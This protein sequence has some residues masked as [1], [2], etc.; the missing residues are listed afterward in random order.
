MQIDNTNMEGILHKYDY[1]HVAF[2]FTPAK[3]PNVLIMIGGMTDGLLTVPYVTQ[4]PEILKPFKYSVIQIQLTS[5]FKGWGTTN[6][7]QDVE[8]IKSLIEYLKSDTQGRDKI[9]IM[10]HSTGSQDVMTYLLTYSDTV[11]A[12]IMQ[13]SVSDREAFIMNGSP[14]HIN[15]L[16]LKAQEL[17]RMGKSN[18]LLSHEY[19]KHTFGTPITAYRWCSLLVPEGDD[20]FFSS[21][22]SVEALK[23][24]FGQIKK[25]FLVA[26]SAEDEFVPSKIDKQQLIN[27]WESVSNSKCWSNQ[28]GLIEGASHN[29]ASAIAQD[30]LFKML[31][32]FFNEFQL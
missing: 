16:T 27:R 2:E 28:S 25:P 4:L 12:G 19:L 6:L 1:G 14:D 29:C 24:S 23:K 31:I 9:V 8:E 3:L 30:N 13:A 11:D 10:G 15:E 18:Q 5:S 22:L 20:D 17:C 7:R 21:D 26:F 32:N